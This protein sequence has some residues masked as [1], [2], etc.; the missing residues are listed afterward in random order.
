[1]LFIYRDESASEPPMTERKFIVF[2]SSLLA[3]FKVCGVCQAP[4][5]VSTAVCGS[6]LRIDVVCPYQHK[7]S[8][9]SQPRLKR[10]PVGSLILCA[11]ICFSGASPEKTLRLLKQANIQVPSTRMYYTYQRVLFQ[12]AIQHVRT[13]Q[14]II[15]CRC[16]Q[17]CKKNYFPEGI[18][19]CIFVCDIIFIKCS[20]APELASGS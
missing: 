4:C 20:L 7:L 10:K 3:L 2:E 13:Q 11:A 19:S 6:M 1:M 16:F 9:H 18:V 17:I 8:W 15:S 14:N 5:K 12:P